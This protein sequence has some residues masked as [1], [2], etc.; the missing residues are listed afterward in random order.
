[1]KPH[2]SQIILSFGNYGTFLLPTYIYTCN[3]TTNQHSPP[4]FFKISAS[5]TR[6]GFEFQALLNI[7]LVFLVSAK[8]ESIFQNGTIYFRDGGELASGC[9]LFGGQ[10]VFS[11]STNPLYDSSCPFIDPEFDCLKFGRPDKLYLNY[12]WKPNSCNLPRF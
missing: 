10:W 11:P 3:S 9:N 6:M 8:A 5:K 7:F 12:S 1:M 4:I 2:A